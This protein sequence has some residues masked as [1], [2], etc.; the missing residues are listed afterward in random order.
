MSVD[1]HQIRRDSMILAI[2]LMGNSALENPN[3]LLK[4]ADA[5]YNYMAE[6]DA[7]STE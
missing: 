2:K 1:I 5:L 6:F 7:F 3:T 4:L